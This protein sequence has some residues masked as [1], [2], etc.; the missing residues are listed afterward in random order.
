M[1]VFRYFRDVIAGEI[2]LLARDGALPV[3]RETSRIA[4][5]LPR[6]PAHGDIATN[7]AMVL[8]KPAGLAPRALAE[9]LAVRLRTHSD[10]TAADVA[11]PGFLNMRLADRFWQ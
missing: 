5:E 3:G 10:V 1:D 9:T 11:G 2:E 6:D 7:A 4:V 8:A